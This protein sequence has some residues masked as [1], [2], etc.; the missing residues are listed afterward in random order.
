MKLSVV[1]LAAVA[2]VLGPAVAQAIT[3][4]QK[5]DFEGGGTENWNLGGTPVSN[6]TTGGPA[7]AGD[8]Y[9][10]LE[11]NTASGPGAKVGIRNGTQ[12]LGDYTAAGV[13]GL[14]MHLNNFSST[15]M[16]MRI[17]IDGDGGAFT[18]SLAFLLGANSGWV[19]ASFDMTASGLTSVGGTTLADT[20]ANVTV[21]TI[22]NDPG[23][24]DGFGLG[25]PDS[26]LGTQVGFDNIKAVPE[27]GT[28]ALL[29]VGVVALATRRRRKH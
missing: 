20:L 17:L 2:L 25:V 24:A 21:F 6:V 18:S 13:T 9:L 23:A 19:G 4:G 3:I 14:T 5:D 26:P 16:E 11:T 27:P 28:L 1:A 10:E 8:N 29:G 7:G 15:A 12:W 22:R